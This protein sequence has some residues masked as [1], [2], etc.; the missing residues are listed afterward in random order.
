MTQEQIIEGN[1]LIAEFMGA[2]NKQ[3]AP[4]IIKAYVQDDEVCFHAEIEP[5]K[6]KRSTYKL[7]ELLYN[8]SWDWLMPV[9]DKIESVIFYPKDI[10]NFSTSFSFII[11]KK[12]V[13]INGITAGY[14]ANKTD[15]LDSKPMAVWLSV[16][17]FIKWYN[18]NK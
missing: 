18:A 10:P 13:I 12:F 14:P 16:V 9:V 17:E 3:T 1:K 7:T 6:E 4:C 8:S 11:H 5:T 2:C 15:V